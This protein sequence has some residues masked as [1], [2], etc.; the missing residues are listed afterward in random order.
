MTVDPEQINT[1]STTTNPHT[2]HLPV[3]TQH[4][5]SQR[6]EGTNR[7]PLMIHSQNITALMNKT[8]IQRM[9]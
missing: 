2:D 8:M 1:A 4:P 3:H 9:I 6:I 5:G 7:S